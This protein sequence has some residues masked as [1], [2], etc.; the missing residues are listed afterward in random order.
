MSIYTKKGDAG[1]TGL[2]SP[3]KGKVIRIS[4]TS[5]RIEAIGSVDEANSFLGICA[6]L[7]DDYFKKKLIKIQQILF[8][9]G[10]TLA[11]AKLPLSSAVVKSMEREI[12]KMDMELTKLTGFILPGG[13]KLGSHLFMARTLI[14][15]AER[16]IVKLS[17]KEKVPSK[18]LVYVNRLSD[19]VYTLAR[20][21]NFK[22]QSKEESWKHK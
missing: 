11:G 3:E 19:Y 14:R 8:T 16:R 10:G 13:G 20:Y 2:Y 5:L 1:E 22:E 17:S 4:K 7:A 21:A 6:N 9:V 18:M 12:D 15:R